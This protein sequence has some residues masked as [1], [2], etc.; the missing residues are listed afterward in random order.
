M[1]AAMA[2]AEEGERGVGRA[3]AG[4]GTLGRSL[5]ESVGM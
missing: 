5:S 1:G 4:R 2:E 3:N